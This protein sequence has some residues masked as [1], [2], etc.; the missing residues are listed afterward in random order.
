MDLQ[1]GNCDIEV[2]QK[3]SFIYEMKLD[4]IL[5]NPKVKNWHNI[6]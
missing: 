5:L 1:L 2:K 4:E 3:I 6:C